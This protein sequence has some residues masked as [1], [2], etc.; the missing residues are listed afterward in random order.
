V[1]DRSGAETV[2]TSLGLTYDPTKGVIAGGVTP[3]VPYTG[4]EGLHILDTTVGHAPGAV[5]VAGGAV[6]SERLLPLCS[7]GEPLCSVAPTRYV[8]F[9]NTDTGFVRLYPLSPAGGTCTLRFAVPAWLVK[10]DTYTGVDI[11]CM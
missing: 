3:R 6:I 11:D 7:S 1:Q 9:V 8:F 4:G 10:P 2:V 5:L